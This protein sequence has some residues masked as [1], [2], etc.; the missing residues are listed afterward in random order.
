MKITV[1]TKE[2]KNKLGQL[3]GVVENKAAIPVLSCVKLSTDNAGGYWLTA[4][5]LATA[6]S[7]PLTVKEAGEFDFFDAVLL[8]V[9]LRQVLTKLS[10]EVVS[11]GFDGTSIAVDAGAFHADIETLPVEQFP[12]TPATPEATLDLDLKKLQTLIK[13]TKF[14]VPEAAGKFIIAASLLQSDGKK[15]SALGTDGIRLAYATAAGEF[16]LF[17]MVLP[18][19]AQNLLEGFAGEKVKA[20]ETESSLFFWNDQA[21]I[22]VRKT[23]SKFPD[24]SQ[25]LK[26]KPVSSV[27]FPAGSLRE[28]LA[29]ASE[30]ADSDRPVS[31]F[32]H[33]DGVLTIETQSGNGTSKENLAVSGEGKF[34]F[35]LNLDFLGDFVDKVEGGLVLNTQATGAVEFLAGDDFKYLLMPV[36]VK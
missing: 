4:N 8:P 9:K 14:A 24:L 13:R 26:T 27:K 18:L 16:G 11:F 35:K 21:T 34:S 36:G 17:E 23:P 10:T 31:G 3:S 25:I 2:L 15:L 22:Y 6:K 20:A 33:D 7:V 29:R 5:D 30:I 12:A 28:A 1:E 19:T 32:S